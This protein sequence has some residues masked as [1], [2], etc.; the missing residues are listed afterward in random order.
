MPDEFKD[1][2]N[3]FL[4]SPCC[5]YCQGTNMS[6]SSE[7]KGVKSVRCSNCG[8]NFPVDGN[9]VRHNISISLVY[10]LLATQGSLS[11]RREY[12]KNLRE[13]IERLKARLSSQDEYEAT[14]NE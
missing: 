12:N 14:T 9:D 8:C 11:R 4:S 1:N 13:Y 2:L 7:S 3:E 10:D 5:P 6:M